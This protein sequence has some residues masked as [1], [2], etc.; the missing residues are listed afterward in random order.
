MK[1]NL[2][3]LKRLEEQEIGDKGLRQRE[4]ERER[5]MKEITSQT[6]VKNIGL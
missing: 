5:T 6:D 1:N 4:R 3:L 2:I